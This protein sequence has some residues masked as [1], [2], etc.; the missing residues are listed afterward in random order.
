MTPL[1]QA[2]DDYLAI[3]RQLGFKLEVD[4]RLLE[5]F[6]AFVDQSGESRVTTEL[7]LAWAKQPTGVNPHRFT[8]RLGIVRRF[9]R[10][11]A[12]LDPDTEI[13]PTDLL[14]ACQQRIA[15][16]IYS[17]GEIE[18]LISAAGV[19]SPPVRAATI[20]TV[21]GLLAATGMRVGEVLALDDT[22][23]DLEGGVITAVGKWG[24][25]REVPLHPSTV[26]ALRE[27]QHTRERYRPTRSTASLFIT[28][29]GQRLTKGAFGES[30]RELIVTVGL[31][32]AGERDRPRPH[33]LR[34]AFA[35]RTL[36]NWHRSGVDIRRQLPWLSTYL[37][38]VSPAD[39]FWYLEA[40]PEL[41]ALAARDLDQLIGGER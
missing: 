34:H 25:Q 39:T 31:E 36:I 29:H 10:Y 33:D 40:V 5:R 11:L 26:A 20:G 35:V 3:R 32:G 18:A 15:P 17:P 23:V 38:H 14:P 41:L 24:K 30:F 16:Y 7:A 22:D 27:Y 21:I 19:L 4:G 2:L 28:R 12:T 37:G 1:R 6:V 13:P 8:Q 9:A